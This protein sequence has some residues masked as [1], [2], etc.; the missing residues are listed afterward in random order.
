MRRA[1]R[2]KQVKATIKLYLVQSS[3]DGKEWH[4]VGEPTVSEMKATT[5]MENYKTAPS[6]AW[7][8]AEAQA[9][10]RHM[11]VIALLVPYEVVKEV[12]P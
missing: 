11:R 12:G 10:I 9:R 3:H 6:A 2:S 5:T 8:P 7:G 1:S 4:P